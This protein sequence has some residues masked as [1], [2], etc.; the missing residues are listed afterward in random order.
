MGQAGGRGRREVVT[1][2]LVFIS[3][4]R[5]PGSP[6]K[7]GMSHHQSAEVLGVRPRASCG[8]VPRGAAHRDL[9]GGLTTSA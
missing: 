3:P 1:L 7:P 2:S 8:L 4:G 6:L 5:V 9:G